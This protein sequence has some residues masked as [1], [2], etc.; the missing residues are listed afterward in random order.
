MVV[1]GGR[2]GGGQ[3]NTAAAGEATCGSVSMHLAANVKQALVADAIAGKIEH[4]ES[5]AAR[6][7]SCNG[8]G[9]F[10][11]QAAVDKV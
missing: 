8:F 3:A 5:G 6:E 1:G 4:N 11:A 9:A 7:K 2:R 10:G